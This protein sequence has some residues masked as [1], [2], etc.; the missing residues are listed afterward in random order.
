MDKKESLKEKA[1]ATA[2][3]LFEHP[4]T[5]SLDLCNLL[6][7]V[8]IYMQEEIDRLTVKIPKQFKKTEEQTGLLKKLQSLPVVNLN[9]FKKESKKY[10]K[11]ILNDMEYQPL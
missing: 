5:A 7:L 8:N 1:E 2:Q 3:R 11:I 6:E 10:W 9:D 4:T